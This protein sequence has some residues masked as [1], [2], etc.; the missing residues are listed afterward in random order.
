MMAAGRAAELGKKVLLLEKNRA[1]GEKLK[2]S[3]GGRCNIT[4]AEPDLRELLRAYGKAEQFLYSTF[5]QFGVT[6]T[7][8]FFESRG[9]P[10]VVEAR[11]RAFQAMRDSR[12]EEATELWLE[13]IRDES[14]VEL[15]L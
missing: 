15:R 6:D 9:L 3:G 13:Q 8:T 11:K 12:V 4:N 7:F 14:Y 1:L 2:I 5:S 10:L